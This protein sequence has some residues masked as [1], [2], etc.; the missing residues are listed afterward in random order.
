MNATDQN[1]I[2]VYLMNHIRQYIRRVQ[3]FL[4]EEIAVMENRMFANELDIE[5]MSDDRAISGN[6]MRSTMND[7][8]CL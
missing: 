3:G 6:F 7:S 4:L 2:S 5:I 8:D 1:S